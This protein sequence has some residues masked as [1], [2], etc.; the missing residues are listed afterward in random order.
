M[1]KLFFIPLILLILS[2]CA[3][4]MTID[5]NMSP[6]EIIQRGQ[7]AMDKNRYKTATQYYQALNERNRTNI[8][9]IITAEYHIAFIHYKQGNYD[10]AREGFNNLLE[11][12]NTPDEELLPHHFKRLSQ[13]VLQNIEEKEKQRN[14]FSRKQKD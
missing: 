6:A 5:E 9:L 7:E 4:M 8:D 3:S 14:P 10:L 2:S 11:Y 1:K 12:Y 13:I